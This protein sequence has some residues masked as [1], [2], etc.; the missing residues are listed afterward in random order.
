MDKFDDVFDTHVSYPDQIAELQMKIDSLEATLES[1]GV[2]SVDW[3]N[4]A[5]AG[6]DTISA[7]HVRIA[8]FVAEEC[9]IARFLEGEQVGASTG[10][11]GNITYG[12]GDLNPDGYWEFP[13][14]TKLVE[15]VRELKDTI[16]ALSSREQ[17]LLLR[18]NQAIFFLNDEFQNEGFIKERLNRLDRSVGRVF[19]S[20]GRS[21]KVFGDLMATDEFGNQIYAQHMDM[22]DDTDD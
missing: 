12:Y 4:E 15:Y 22:G 17:N 20:H 10:V 7:Q 21:A 11:C 8:G 16:E 13:V 9:G 14:P 1:L 6:R 19:A 3:M 18:M 5:I 2:S